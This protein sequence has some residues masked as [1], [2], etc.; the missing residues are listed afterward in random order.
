M[1]GKTSD[2]HVGWLQSKVR[3]C[4]T[5]DVVMRIG[6]HV[7]GRLDQAARWA[8]AAARLMGVSAWLR[9]NSASSRR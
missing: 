9:T 1:R 6:A 2:Q 5:V 4:R 8:F 3:H 7:T